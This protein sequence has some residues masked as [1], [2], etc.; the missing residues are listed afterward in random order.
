MVGEF[1]EE[2]EVL[3]YLFE[4]VVSDDL[5]E[6]VGL[7]AAI[8]LHDLLAGDL[9]PQ[10]ILQQMRDFVADRAET[11]EDDLQQ[12][13]HHSLHEHI[14]AIWQDCEL[15]VSLQESGVLFLE[16]AM[17][18]SYFVDDVAVVGDVLVDEDAVVCLVGMHDFEYVVEDSEEGVLAAAHVL[19]QLVQVTLEHALLQLPRGSLHVYSLYY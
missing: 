18:A 13:V 4:L 17:G 12:A 7:A 14:A 5:E 19:H 11:V 9:Q 16:L 15:M 2:L 10:V 1:S 6:Q 8:F 3:A